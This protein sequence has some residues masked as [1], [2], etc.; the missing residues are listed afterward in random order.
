MKDVQ[1]TRPLILV[2]GATG[3]VG[4]EPVKQLAATGKPLTD[5][6]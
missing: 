2:V 5:A 3:T 1:M 4:T 6:A